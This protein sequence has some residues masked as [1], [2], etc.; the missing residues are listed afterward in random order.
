ML[1]ESNKE[2][3]EDVA[4]YSIDRKNFTSTNENGIFELSIFPPSTILVF[5]HP[6]F[7]N[8]KISSEDILK[9][10]ER[11]LLTERIIK[12]DEVVISANKWEQN[13]S[14]IPYEILSIST[15]EMSFSNPQ[16]SADMLAASGQVFVQKSQLGGG[17]PMIRG[18]GANSVLIVVDGVRMNNAI[19]R[20]GNL[21]NVISIDPNTL[22]SSEV[23]FG[24]GAVIYG[25]DALGGVMDF[26]T[27]TPRYA[28]EN[29]LLVEG[30]GLAR[31][32]SANN[33]KTINGLVSMSK[34]N[35][36]YLGSLTVSDFGN[37]KTGSIRPDEY[38]DFGK[39]PEYIIQ[40]NGMD[41]IV[42]NADENRQKFSG[43]KQLST[44]QKIYLRIKD[45]ME[46]GYTLNLSTTS[47]IP[48]YERLIEYDGENLKN[49]EWNYGPQKWMMHA[50]RFNY[51]K[52]NRLFDESKVIA[53]FQRFEESRH[54]RRYRQISLRS[55]TEKVDVL[56]FNA[57]FEKI[58]NKNGQLFYGLAYT[59]NHVNS[60]AYA[61]DIE[62]GAISQI[63]TRYPNGGSD[64][65]NA[66]LYASYKK[67]ITDKVVLNTG[68]RYSYQGLNSKFNRGSFDY[69][70]IENV[71]SAINGNV[72]LVFNPNQKWNF[73]GLLSSGFRA[74]NVDDISK[75]FDSEPGNVVVPNPTLKPEYSYNTEASVSWFPNKMFSI[76]GTVFYSFLHNA[77]VRGDFT[78]NGKDSIIYD[79]EMSKVQAFV[80]TGRA[81]IYGLVSFKTAPNIP[82]FESRLAAGEYDFAYMNP[83]HYTVFNQT[84]GYLALARA[85]DKRIKGILVV[86]KDSEIKQ[87][88]D[89]EGST[90]AFPA[91]AAF[92]ASILSQSNLKSAGVKF[93]SKYVSS[94]D[95]VYRTVAKGLYPAGGG[96][97]RT[98]NNVEAEIRDQLRV[99]WTS[100][101]YTPHA[102][103]VHPRVNKQ[104][105]QA[106][107]QALVNLE[108][109]AEGA[110]LLKG[111]KIKGF[112]I[113]RDSDWD[114]VRGLE[115]KE[116]SDN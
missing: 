94:H 9:N 72:G 68:I 21:Q 46:L 113:A 115:L 24:P 37:L 41:S 43:Y 59:Y 20:G 67:G 25:S 14:E 111:I 112:E 85:R 107:Q 7:Y 114:D 3:V 39:R 100:R 54:D 27:I 60:T 103:A 69:D 30:H 88:A 48:R 73:S 105:A 75:I 10:G 86:R 44:L 91:P 33:E 36:S 97:V 12:I 62:T 110:A 23:I 78:I 5:Q 108:Q 99:L 79:G 34:R 80:N 65:H 116:L 38:P 53:A 19:F 74:P 71:S 8:K 89:L 95:S 58:L 76:N 56:L 87:L 17:S 26:H 28:I 22:E 49:A 83:Y 29:N 106:L 64:V 98:L 4:I 51:F 104:D 45:H 93:Q 92:A 90:L 50:L 82:A 6:S 109:K 57:D 32:S 31:Y 2:P 15:K 70:K 42:Q 66:A 11:I 13:K 16:T 47:D 52:A 102:I 1:N 35:F 61:K 40:I 63:S 101:G 96:V 84:S 81:N 77:M 18:F 55:R